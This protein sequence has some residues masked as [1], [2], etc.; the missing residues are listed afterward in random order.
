MQPEIIFFDMGYTLIHSLP[1]FEHHFCSVLKEHG[2][3]KPHE[4]VAL[5]EP[6]AWKRANTPPVPFTLSTDL[7]RTF[8]LSYYGILLEELGLPRLD[9]FCERLYGVLSNS[10]RYGLYADVI[11][12]LEELKRRGFRLGVISNWE[13]WL[14]DR[15]D[16]LDIRRFFD[17][18]VISGSVGLEKPNPAI[19]NLALKRAGVSA[20]RAMHVGDSIEC[21][22]RPAT[23]LGFQAILID[24]RER[25]NGSPFPYV[26]SLDDL[27]EHMARLL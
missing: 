7:S 13:Y 17:P 4:E 2:I 14:E 11:P 27:L 20:S 5:V 21:D 1:S 25:L 10:E 19:F 12:G 23:G 6:G 16:A 15:L 18:V 9:G 26:R 3:E 8:W 22:Y 24:R